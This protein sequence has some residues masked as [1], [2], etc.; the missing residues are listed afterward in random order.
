MISQ[1]MCVSGD[2]R[3]AQD[4][5]DGEACEA[6]LLDTGRLG[7]QSVRRFADAM[8]ACYRLRTLSCEAVLS[9]TALV[10][11]EGSGYILAQVAPAALMRVRVVVDGDVRW[12]P[13]IGGEP[14]EE[15]Q[16]VAALVVP[17]GLLAVGV[18][19]SARIFITENRNAAPS[20]HS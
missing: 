3:L 18:S 6:L 4:V 10:W 7:V 13:V 15:L 5:A 19:P 8:H 20:I 14:V 16:A 1:R 2:G 12:E 11:P 17:D 9:N